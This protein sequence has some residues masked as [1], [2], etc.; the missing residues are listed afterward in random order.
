[1]STDPMLAE[2]ARTGTRD[3]RR[4]WLLDLFEHTD[5]RLPEEAT[6]M[7]ST[8]A[9]SDAHHFLALYTEEIGEDPLPH[10]LASLTGRVDRR[11]AADALD[12][13][14]DHHADGAVELVWM[15]EGRRLA[16]VLHLEM[17]DPL[18]ARDLVASLDL[19]EAH[20][21]SADAEAG[22]VDR[23]LA[24]ERPRS[25]AEQRAAKRAKKA[26]RKNRRR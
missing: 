11:L 4:A 18:R 7:L 6:R 24:G 5:P 22:W 16:G 10:V 9:A 15:H 21:A 17:V 2:R 8:D 25:R 19:V 3:D 1:M 14:D 23:W 12:L 20:L 13:I 26:K